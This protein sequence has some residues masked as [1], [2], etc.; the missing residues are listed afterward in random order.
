MIIKAACDSPWVKNIIDVHH[1]SGPSNTLGAR[2]PLT[3]RFREAVYVV[4]SFKLKDE[5]NTV[6]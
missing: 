4:F 1:W 5:L 3:A 2:G 6:S